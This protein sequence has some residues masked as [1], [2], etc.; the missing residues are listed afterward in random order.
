MVRVKAL[1][2]IRNNI[3][4]P[5]RARATGL[6]V[7]LCQIANEQ[8]VEG[9]HERLVATWDELARR[10][11]LSKRMLTLLST[12][13]NV[14]GVARF[15]TRVDALRG[16]LPSLIHLDVHDGPWVGLTVATAREVTETSRAGLLPALGLLATLLE[17]CAEQRAVLGGLCAET[18]RADVARRVGCSTDT[19]DAWVKLL[20]GIDILNVTRRRGTDGGH[21]PNLWEILEPDPASKRSSRG[22]DKNGGEALSGP[23]IGVGDSVAARNGTTLAANGNYPDGRTEPPGPRIETAIADGETRP[24]RSTELPRPR[25]RDAPAENGNWP[26]GNSAT[27]GFDPRPLNARTRTPAETRGVEE[28][29]NPQTPNAPT[30]LTEGGEE[31]DSE[32]VG[33]C[34]ELVRVLAESR[35]PAPG[36]RYSAEIALWH[37]SARRV[38]ADHPVAKVLE[39]IAY[40]PCDQIVGTKVRGMPDLERHIED[41]RHRAHA[42][43]VAAG[44]RPAAAPP[45]AL[46]WPEAKAVLMR[47][48]QRHGA[49]ARQAA[50]LELGER[51]PLLRR[52][53]EQVG[54]GALCQSPID[55]QDCAYRTSWDDLSR[56]A[57][58]EEAAA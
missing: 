41:L 43:C 24:G 18:T 49:G 29:Q 50:L 14:A 57:A 10:G 17:L 34:V 22:D 32:E 44:V 1:Q 38:L 33:L 8:R 23:A 3:S 52:F 5:R 58:T 7:L 55:K 45:A 47:A 6:Y 54:W 2:D 46:S 53:A 16:S 39:A 9:A 19:L 51:D 4:G 37:A 35:G 21:L 40:L 20:E 36:R 56:Q 11:A 31:G 15:E 12:T 26:P 42:A 28:Q 30:S 13:L 27:S 48:V 25:S